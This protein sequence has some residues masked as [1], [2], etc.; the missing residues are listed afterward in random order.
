MRYDRPEVQEHL[1][2]Q[3][4]LGTLSVRA[5]RRLQVLA[6]TRPGQRARLDDWA[7]RLAV[8]SATTAPQ[9][10]SALLWAGITARTHSANARQGQVGAVGAALGAAPPSR[11]LRWLEAL[12]SPAW[13]GAGGLVAGVLVTT[14]LWQQQ[15]QWW[16]DVEQLGRV[17]Q[18]LPQSY[19][20]ILGDTQGRTQVLVSSTRHGRR[21]F[22]KTLSPLALQAGETLQLRAR[23]PGEAPL[24]LGT[25]T[26]AKGLVE[27]RLPDSAEALFKRVTEL[28][29]VASTATGPG[30][31]GSTTQVLARGPCAKL[32]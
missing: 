8:L 5:R 12:R 31:P 6:S 11:W 19:V 27:M 13:V 30:L 16:V 23:V 25:L 14:V 2:A 3:C 32:W 20:G 4:M 15:P 28:E 22:I 26:G 21:L 24:L 10:P 18:A 17:E 1:A 29:V 7:E 9:V